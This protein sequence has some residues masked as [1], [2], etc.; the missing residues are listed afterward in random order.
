MTMHNLRDDRPQTIDDGS[1]SP[2][3]SRRS[4]IAEVLV[5]ASTTLA[6]TDFPRLTAEALLAHALSVTRTRLLSHPEGS[7]APKAL[8]EFEQLIARAAA[9][10]PLAYLTGHREFYGLD[11]LVDRRVLVPRPETERL[12]DL[13]LS[14]GHPSTSPPA[15][16][17]I[18]DVGT[19][20]GCIAVA[21]AKHLPSARI[22]ATDVSAEALAV[23]RINA[24]RHNVS[25]RITFV[26][27]DL[28]SSFVMRSGHS[29]FDLLCANL[30]YIPSA[31]LRQLPISEHEPMLALD[32]GPDGLN[33]ID[34]LLTGAARVAAPHGRLLLEIGATQGAPVCNLARAAFPSAQVVLHKDLAGLDRVVAVDF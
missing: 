18:L 32:G 5:W 17:R 8:A 13:A 20:C 29:S 28:L 16:L 26:H 2:V 4:S 12:V 23:A 34:R 19:G 21:L 31:E 30:P 3:V 6:H 10:E 14:P 24:G 25:E 27:T 11:F 1:P 7:V 22:T 9:G 15:P 33:L